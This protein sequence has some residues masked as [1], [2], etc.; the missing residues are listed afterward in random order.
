ML[1][2]LE[3]LLEVMSAQG[4]AQ[5]QVNGA[6]LTRPALG[7]GYGAAGSQQSAE[8]SGSGMVPVMEAEPRTPEVA[9][10]VPQVPQDSQESSGSAVSGLA[11]LRC[12][13]LQRMVQL[14]RKERLQRLHL[15]RGHRAVQKPVSNLLRRLL[16]QR[17]GKDVWRFRGQMYRL[18]RRRLR[19]R[20]L[21]TLRRGL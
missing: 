17:A 3:T 12:Q 8:P 7:T 2:S 1:C 9:A 11:V 6:P 5:A 10:T 4:A 15:F 18:Q 13:K 16:G 19:R 20:R 14:L 21:V